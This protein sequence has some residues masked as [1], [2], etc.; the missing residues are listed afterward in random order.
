[1][2]DNAAGTGSLTLSPDGSYTL[3]L[4]LAATVPG[5]AG[6][7]GT[8][9]DSGTWKLLEKDQLQFT[10]QNQSWTLDGVPPALKSLIQGGMDSMK[11]SVKQAMA[12]P[13]PVTWEEKRWK[14]SAG[15]ARFIFQRNAV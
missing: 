7:K 6:V 15:S 4:N 8:I 9:N 14:I 1:M 11:N 13:I 3:K 12:N 2:M 10:V 5:M